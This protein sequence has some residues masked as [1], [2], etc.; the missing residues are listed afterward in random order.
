MD[1]DAG[2][3]MDRDAG[4][5]ATA[6]I[7]NKQHLHTQQQHTSTTHEATAYTTAAPTTTAPEAP[8]SRQYRPELKHTAWHKNRSNITHSNTIHTNDTMATTRAATAR[9]LKESISKLCELLILTFPY[10]VHCTV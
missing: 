6:H 7:K 3:I 5:K 9:V 2:A 10:T 4:A 1:R 8:A